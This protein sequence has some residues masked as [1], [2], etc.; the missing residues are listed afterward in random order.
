M[1]IYEYRHLK[2]PEKCREEFEIIEVSVKAP[3]KICPDCGKP[4]ERILSN[5]SCY[6]NILADSNLKD[7][8]FTKM[9]KDKEKGGY[10]KIV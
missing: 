4:V 3:I 2:K 9:V 10:R 7:K 1:P 8:G 5:F 6:D